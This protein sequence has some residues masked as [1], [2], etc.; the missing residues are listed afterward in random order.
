MR[1]MLIAA[2]IVIATGCATTKIAENVAKAHARVDEAAAKLHSRIDAD[3]PKLDKINQDLTAIKAI[4][5][6]Q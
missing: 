1:Y 5:D 3:A 6:A 4:I 2:M